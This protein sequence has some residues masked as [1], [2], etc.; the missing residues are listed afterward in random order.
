VGTLITPAADPNLDVRKAAVK[1]LAP[2]L[3]GHPNVREA[4]VRAQGDVDADV[5]AFARIALETHADHSG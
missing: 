4:L 2:R 3:P 5:R 1:A